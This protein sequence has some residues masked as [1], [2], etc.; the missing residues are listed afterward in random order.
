MNGVGVV[1]ALAAEARA[2]GATGA[3]SDGS[4]LLV[5]G[6]GAAAA[7]SAASSLIDSRVTAL[8]TFGLAGGLDP[9]LAAGAIVLPEEVIAR[10]GSRFATS[11]E[12]LDRVRAAMHER[13]APV[14]GALLTSTVALESIA[15]KADAFRDTG[16]VAVDME[17]V[18]VAQVAAAHRLPFHRG[19]RD[20]RH[21]GGCAAAGGS[22]GEPCRPRPNRPADCWSCCSRP[23]KS[24]R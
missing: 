8:M 7:A 21:G 23:V 2:L 9:A 18:A 5:S 22:G 15:D 20:R 6:I 3:R 1:A 10:D 13:D 16:A 14:G 24:P 19:A 17:S 12:W 11:S 4:F